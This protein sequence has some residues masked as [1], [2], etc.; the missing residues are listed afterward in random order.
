[1]AKLDLIAATEGDEDS[2]ETCCSC[3]SSAVTHRALF[4]S[5]VCGPEVSRAAWCAAGVCQE[6]RA[7]SEVRSVPVARADGGGY[8]VADVW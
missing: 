5:T 3:G 7:R 6:D 4:V 1:M 8:R 2:F